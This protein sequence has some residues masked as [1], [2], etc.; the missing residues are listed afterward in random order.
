M[1]ATV[2]LTDRYSVVDINS[3]TTTMLAYIGFLQ[4]LTAL[5]ASE[6]VYLAVFWQKYDRLED[7]TSM[8]EQ[9]RGLCC[10]SGLKVYIFCFDTSFLP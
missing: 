2:Y 5:T 4:Q 10:R 9:R 1:P 6:A 8:H 3:I 7:A